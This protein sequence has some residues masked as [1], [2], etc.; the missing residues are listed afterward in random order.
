MEGMEVTGAVFSREGAELK[1]VEPEGTLSAFE[2]GFLGDIDNTDDEKLTQGLFL[3]NKNNTMNK[4]H[5]ITKYYHK[6][7]KTTIK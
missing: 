2:I 1:G 6:T 5:N 3:K 4:G 7:T